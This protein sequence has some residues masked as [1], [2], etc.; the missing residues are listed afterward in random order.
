VD[1][2]Q[3]RFTNVR[4]RTCEPGL[5]H[6]AEEKKANHPREKGKIELGHYEKKWRD[7]EKDDATPYLIKNTSWGQG[8]WVQEPLD[9]TTSGRRG[10]R[11]GTKLFLTNRKRK[12]D[13]YTR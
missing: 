4:R 9:P 13:V 8:I 2:G 3:D 6:V 10:K 11:G 5:K 7:R 12:K 1:R